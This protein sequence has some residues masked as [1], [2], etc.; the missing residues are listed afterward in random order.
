MRKPSYSQ[1]IFA[2]MYL[3]GQSLQEAVIA[4]QRPETGAGD[5]F[6]NY[7]RVAGRR[8]EFGI[9]RMPQLIDA[10]AGI[11][12]QVEGQFGQSLEC[13]GRAIRAAEDVAVS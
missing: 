13:G 2:G 3:H 9:H 6:Q 12:A 1:V 5:A 11:P 10:V 7:D 4:G 8:P